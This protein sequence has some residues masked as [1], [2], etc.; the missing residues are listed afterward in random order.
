[1]R[2]S[3]ES[4]VGRGG[5]CAAMNSS[6]VPPG[7]TATVAGTGA[8]SAPLG[9]VQG[10]IRATIFGAQP[11]QRLELAPPVVVELQL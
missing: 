10:W 6:I 4:L 5:R 1:M 3:N 11:N 7:V 8:V 2:L 9:P